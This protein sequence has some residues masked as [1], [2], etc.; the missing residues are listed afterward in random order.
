MSMKKRLEK[1]EAAVTPP[2]L[3]RWVRV[4]KDLGHCNETDAECIRRHGH[5]PDDPELHFIVLTIVACP[6]AG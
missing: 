3:E 1:L 4:I 2:K 5:D 6:P